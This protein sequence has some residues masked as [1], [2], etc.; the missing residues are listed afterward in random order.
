MRDIPA[1]WLRADSRAYQEGSLMDEKIKQPGVQFPSAKKQEHVLI[2]RLDIS[3]TAIKP[4]LVR[5][6][7]KRLCRLFERIENCSKRADELLD[8]GSLQRSPLSNFNFSATIG[9]G[10]TFFERLNIPKKNQPNICLQMNHN[11]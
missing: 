5:D 2:I 9:F 3:P 6:G 11:D 10:I 7:L 4:T 1:Y 8:D